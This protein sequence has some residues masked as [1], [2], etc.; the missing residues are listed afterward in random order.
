MAEGWEKHITQEGCAEKAGMVKSV[1]MGAVCRSLAM[2]PE[3]WCKVQLK[4]ICDTIYRYPG[5][6]GFDRHSEGVPVIRGEHIKNGKIDTKDD[7]LYFVTVKIAQEFPK[8]ILSPGDLVM[9]VRGTIGES[10]LRKRDSQRRPD[11]SKPH[12]NFP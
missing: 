5:F 12:S 10:G 7:Q 4:D 11:L 6:Y 9:S 1:A 8:T 3:G 2:V